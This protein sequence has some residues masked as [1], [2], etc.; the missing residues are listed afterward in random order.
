MKI[1]IE[2]QRLY[3]RE[4]TPDDKNE[5]SEVLS[6][7]QSM[8][9]YPHPF[10]EQ[11]VINWIKWNIDNYEKY[12]HG[13]WAIILKQDNSFL[14]DCGITM[15]NIEDKMLP[16]IGYHIKKEY[17]NQGYATE[18][19]MACRNY[20]FG[21]LNYDAIF[22]Y[23][24]VDNKPS[25]RVAEKNGMTKIKYFKKMVSGV[26]VEDVLYGI[27]RQDIGYITGK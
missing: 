7:R 14:G 17:R 25:I 16:E 3:L 6:D 9:Y 15:Q 20:A 13:L 12:N 4:L 23:T 19:A 8:I 5:L 11:E 10:S 24:S 26:E 2:T 21:T 22:T 27:T 1:I 18:A